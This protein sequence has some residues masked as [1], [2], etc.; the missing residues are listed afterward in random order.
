[1]ESAIAEFKNNIAPLFDSINYEIKSSMESLTNNIVKIDTILVRE[2]IALDSII[3]RE[4][5]E[6]SLKADEL[7]QTGIEKAFDGLSQLVK[8]ILI[9]L[10]IFIIVL[11]GVPFYLGY[12]YGK[13]K[14]N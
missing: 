13:K 7:V 4:R 8:N 9:F 5:Q 3:Q 6:L 12:L 11:F 14:S 2:R 10:I 1:L